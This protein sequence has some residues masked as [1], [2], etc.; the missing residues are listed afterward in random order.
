MFEKLTAAAL[1]LAFALPGAALA[2]SDMDANGDGSVTMEEFNAAMPDAGEA[3]FT[4]ADTNGDGALSAD[5][6]AAARENGI[7]PAS[8]G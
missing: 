2:A 4:E 7:L 1:A 8:D 3:V 5:E 6:I